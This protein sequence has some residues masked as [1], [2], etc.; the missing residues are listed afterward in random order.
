MTVA[1]EA[2]YM[3]GSDEDQRK[4]HRLNPHQPVSLDEL[5]KLG[6]F[7]WKLNADLYETDPELEKIR[8]DRGYSYMDI[9]TIQRDSLPNYDEKVTFDSVLSNELMKQR[10]CRKL[11][12]PRQCKSEFKQK[13]VRLRDTKTRLPWE[14]EVEGGGDLLPLPY[15]IERIPRIMSMR[16]FVGEPVWKAY[17]RP[18]DDFDIRQKYVASLQGS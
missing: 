14:L 18:A 6:V 16:L 13:S 1:D 2:W 4:P 15:D 5:K 7:Y 11:N 17:N 8:K 3:D 10:V 9:I 12:K